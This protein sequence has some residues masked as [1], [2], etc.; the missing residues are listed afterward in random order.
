MAGMR[1][2]RSDRPLGSAPTPFQIKVVSNTGAYGGHASETLASALGSPLTSYRCPNKKADGFAVY[3]NIVPGG[4]FRGY[5]A[6]QSTFAI[7]CAIAELGEL[8]GMDPFA[9]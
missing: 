6:S 2:R 9:I 1:A 4:G 7:E 8:L 5:G 3:T